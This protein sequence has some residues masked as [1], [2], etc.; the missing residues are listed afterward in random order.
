MNPLL[1]GLLVAL[2]MTLGIGPS[3]LLY[4]QA[5]IQRGFIAG[6][7]VL[8]GIWVSDIGFVFVNYLGI[9]QIFNTVPHQRIAA[10]ISASVLLAL[11]SMQWM[12][13]PAPVV[14]Q[15]AHCFLILHRPRTV[16]A[17]VAAIIKAR[18]RICNEVMTRSQFG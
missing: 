4:F 9:S 7:A 16:L 17:M 1:A 8:S 6:L 5:T 10:V 12:R 11:G 3:L 13:K 2:L 14:C 15:P 18:S